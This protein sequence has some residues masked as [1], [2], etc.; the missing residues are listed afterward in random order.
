MNIVFVHRNQELA[1]FRYRCAIPGAELSKSHE[2]FFNGGDASVCIFSKPHAD[3]IDIA[4]AARGNGCHI[5]VDIG[6]DHFSHPAIGPVYN[7]MLEIADSVVCPTQNMQTRLREFT[8]K[9]ITVI[10]DPYE[11]PLEEPHADGEEFIW[12]GHQSNLGDLRRYAS[13]IPALKIVTGPQK[14]KGTILYSPESLSKAMGEANISLLPTRKGVEYKS[15]NRL[16]NS[17][18]MGLF[19]VCDEH[20]AYEEFKD[21]AWTSGLFHGVAWAKHF[22]S[23]LNGLVKEG[24]EYIEKYS[25]ENVGEIWLD[26]I[27]S[28]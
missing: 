22:R 12:F 10:P 14:I 25:P 28:I 13:D 8:E 15:P 23:D 24:Q 27:D 1:S 18:R 7:R 4:A 21:F 9:D 5:V 3:D 6:D 11:M 17:L 26:F 19:P 20:P 16:L 2:V